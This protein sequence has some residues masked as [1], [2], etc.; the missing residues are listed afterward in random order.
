MSQHYYSTFYQEKP[1]LITMGWDRPLG[2]FF[3]TIED[4]EKKS[5]GEEDYLIYSNLDEE[6]DRMAYQPSLHHYQGVLKK[7]GIDLPAYILDEV[8]D[9]ALENIGNKTVWHNPRHF[10]S[11]FI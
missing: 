8:Y 2:Y 4:E 1:I 7:L 5:R 9:D 6:E 11:E 10:M 3:M